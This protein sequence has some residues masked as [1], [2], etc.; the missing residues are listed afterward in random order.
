MNIGPAL[1][2]AGAVAVVVTAVVHSIPTPQ[3]VAGQAQD[4]EQVLCLESICYTDP[5]YGKECLETEPKITRLH[6]VVENG[7]VKLVAEA[8]G[9]LC[10]GE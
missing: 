2:L 1:I 7:R 10:R 6:Q 3:P 9:G 5:V 8:T 4:T